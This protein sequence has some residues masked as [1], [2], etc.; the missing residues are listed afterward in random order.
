[1]SLFN[2]RPDLIALEDINELIGEVEGKRLDVKRGAY[3]L[4][5]VHE[6]DESTAERAKAIEHAKADL[7]TDVC[8]MANAQGGFIVLGAKDNKN[9][10][11]EVTGLSLNLTTEQAV[12]HLQDA[13]LS[14]IEPALHGLHVQPVLI[15][16][17]ASLFVIVICVP[18]SLNAPHRVKNG[19]RFVIRQSVNNSDMDISEIRNAFVAGATYVE[20]AQ[21]L[22]AERLVQLVQDRVICSSSPATSGP[23][24]VVH[25]IPLAS[26]DETLVS[27]SPQESDLESLSEDEQVAVRNT[28]LTREFNIYGFY[29]ILRRV[30]GHVADYVQCFTSG[31]IEY[32]RTVDTRPGT[33]EGSVRYLHVTDL[34]EEIGVATRRSLALQRALRISPPI[35]ISVSLTSVFGQQLGHANPHGDS[36]GLSFATHFFSMPDVA[37]ERYPVGTQLLETLKPIHNTLANG[38]GLERSPRFSRDGA[39][40]LPLVRPL[41]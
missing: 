16:E 33:T 21:R 36:I 8:A 15:S 38:A 32:V 14:G 6:E 19:Q 3:H 13:A 25:C 23:K 41:A 5:L 31:V 26:I 37:I 17:E 11:T 1:M 39:V 2:K 7:C 10:V 34:D 28:L 20:R 24:V 29:S 35:L 18:R 9:T 30:Q 40:L 4:S 22:R 12:R 27:L